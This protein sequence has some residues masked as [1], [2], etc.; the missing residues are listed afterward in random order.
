[1]LAL[2]RSACVLD[3]IRR[4]DGDYERSYRRLALSRVRSGLPDRGR[5]PLLSV[6]QADLPAVLRHQA[7]RSVASETRFRKGVQRMPGSRVEGDMMGQDA[8]GRAPAHV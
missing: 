3:R 2:G 5:R 6:L 4:D 7:E 8:R 1:M